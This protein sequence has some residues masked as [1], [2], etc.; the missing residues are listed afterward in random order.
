MGA[1]QGTEG[2]ALPGRLVKAQTC[3]GPIRN[4]QMLEEGKP[5]LMV[6]FPGERGTAN[7]CKQAREAGVPVMVVTADAC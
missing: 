2:R 3:R 6:A 1:R 7:M 5:D 4:K